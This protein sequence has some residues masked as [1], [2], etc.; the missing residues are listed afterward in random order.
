MYWL[1]DENSRKII[2]LLD[3]N[4]STSVVYVHKKSYQDFRYYLER[5]Q[6]EYSF[7]AGLLWLEKYKEIWKH[8]KYKANRLAIYQLNDMF[9]TG[10]ISAQHIYENSPSYRRLPDWCRATL[11]QSLAVERL[12][13]KTVYVDTKRIACSHFLDYLCA[14]G[15]Q[16]FGEITY[17]NIIT[18]HSLGQ[19]TS[20]KS[21]DYYEGI[22][23]N[24]LEYLYHKICLPLS[25]SLS[26]NKFNIPYIT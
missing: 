2:R 7:E 9:N 5:T 13:F 22:V 11:D 14:E 8:S 16:E 20:Q 15:I 6:T 17:H 19:H 26:L 25:L 18:Y 21:R 4:Y 1:Y 3:T 24:Y 23:R 10:T 12:S